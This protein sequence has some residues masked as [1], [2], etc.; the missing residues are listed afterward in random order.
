[1]S[2]LPQVDGALHNAYSTVRVCLLFRETEK[3]FLV[4]TFCDKL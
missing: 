3:S 4:L 1:M 2:L